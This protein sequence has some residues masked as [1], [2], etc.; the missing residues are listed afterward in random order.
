VPL[1]RIGGL[2]KGER[3]YA[4]RFIEDNAYVVTFRQV[5]PLYVLDLSTPSRPAVR[6]ELKIR[7]YSAY[8][9]PVAEDLLLGIGQD[10]TDDG[11]VVG[12]QASLFDVSDPR[13]PRRLDAFPLGKGWS[14]AEQDHHA[15]LWWPRS[16][17][18]VLP[19]QAYGDAPFVGALGLRV[20]RVGGITE[21]GRVAHPA[22]PGGGG[23]PGTPIRRTV[24]VGDALYTVSAAG[25]RASALGSFADLGFAPLPRPTGSPKQPVPSR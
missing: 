15:F 21:V 6:G 24:V 3:V 25:V 19:L 20:A 11:R 18:A 23:S 1:G 22:V 7:G 4:V 17:L 5:D 9:H 2:G 10:A 16:R 12:A 8:L 13:Q 14:E